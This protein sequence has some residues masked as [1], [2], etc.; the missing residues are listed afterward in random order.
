MTRVTRSRSR[1][2][3]STRWEVTTS[4]GSITATAVVLAM[5]AWG[6]RLRQLRRRVLVVGSDIVATEGIP[7]RLAGIGW[8]DGLC[9]SDSRLLVHYYRTTTD[10]RVVFGKGW[11]KPRL[12]TQGRTAVR[13]CISA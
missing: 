12:G 9:I 4:E 1:G 11:R 5:N 6:I 13:R 10:G 8:T 3:F 2:G 7:E